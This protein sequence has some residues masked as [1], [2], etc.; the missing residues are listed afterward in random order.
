M[1]NSND[2]E[3][4]AVRASMDDYDAESADLKTYECDNCGHRVKAE[5][6]PE[7][8]PNC[9]GDMFDISVSRE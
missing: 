6:Q 4:E 9:G 1:G 2:G 3:D 5:H 7:V 8:C